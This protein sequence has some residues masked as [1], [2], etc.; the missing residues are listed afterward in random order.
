M[1]DDVAGGPHFAVGGFDWNLQFNWHSGAKK[2][3]HTNCFAKIVSYNFFGTVSVPEHEVKR[4]NHSWEPAWSPTMA[5]GLFAIDKVNQRNKTI[6][7]YIEYCRTSN[8][9]I[10]VVAIVRNAAFVRSV[11]LTRHYSVLFLHPNN[12]YVLVNYVQLLAW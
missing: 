5:G 3:V 8:R 2:T 4:R 9:S 7:I 6:Y 1:H 11:P 12:K 10:T